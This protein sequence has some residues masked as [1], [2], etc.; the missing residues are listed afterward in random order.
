MPDCT[1]SDIAVIATVITTVLVTVQTV[2]SYF[3]HEHVKS[4]NQRL[5]HVIEGKTAKYQDVK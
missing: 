4:D 5:L 1:Q 3:R 2:V